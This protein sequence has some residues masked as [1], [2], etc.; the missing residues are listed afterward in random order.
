[1]A[2]PQPIAELDDEALSQLF[3]NGAIAKGHGYVD[4]MGRIEVAGHT[5]SASMQG[6]EPQPYRT[7][8]RL[9]R[10]EFFGDLSVEIV[11]RCTCPVGN[12]CKHAVALLM[13]ARR[14]RGA[15]EA[16]PRGGVAVGD[17]PQEA[18]RRQGR[19][20][21]QGRTSAAR[22]HPLRHPLRAWDGERRVEPV[23][24]AASIPRAVSAAAASPGTRPSRPC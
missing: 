2:L 4:R 3:S 5:L 24:R 8:V 12:R 23:Q 14:P 18:A 10:R 13:A 16:A 15:G 20:H 1:M 17:G 9:A 11:T 22:R 21:Q 19:H 7:S 6:G